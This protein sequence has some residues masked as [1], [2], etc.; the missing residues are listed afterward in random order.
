MTGVVYTQ[1]ELDVFLPGLFPLQIERFYRSASADRDVGMGHGW[2]HTLAWWIEITRRGVRVHTNDGRSVEMQKPA[3]QGDVVVGR[4]AWKLTGEARG[5]SLDMNDGFRRFFTESAGPGDAHWVLTEVRDKNGNAIRLDYDRGLLMGVRDTV[6]RAVRV[7]RARSG[8]IEAFEMRNAPE[9]GRW[10]PFVTYAYD[11]RRDLVSVTDA[12]GIAMRFAYDA[13]HRLVAEAHPSGLVFHFIYD[14]HGHCTET[15]GDYGG[16]PI[17]GL[18]ADVPAVLSN[19]RTRAK[20]IYHAKIDYHMAGQT[21]VDDSRCLRRV[22]GNSFG[23]IDKLATGSRVTTWNYNKV[24]QPVSREDPLNRVSRWQYGDDGMMRSYQD[25]SGATTT[26]ERDEHG[27]IVR[28]LEED[29]ATDIARNQAGNVTATRDS[30]G[31]VTTYERDGRGALAALIE[32]NGAR[33]EY[34]YDA[35]YNLV[36]LVDPLGRSYRWAYDAFGRPVAYRNPTNAETLYTYTDGGRELGVFLPNRGALRYSYDASGFLSQLELPDGRTALLRWGHYQKIIASVEPDGRTTTFSYD[37]EG[38]L[39]RVTNAAGEPYSFDRNAYGEATA[40]HTFDGRT[41][42]FDRDLGGRLVQFR[43]GAGELTEFTYDSADQILKME[44]GDGLVDSFEYDRVGRIVGATSDAAKLELKRDAAGNVVRELVT[45]NGV[46]RTIDRAYDENDEWIE[47]RTSLGHVERVDRDALGNRARTQLD[48]TWIQHAR[49]EIGRE[50]V[51]SLPKGAFL[52]REWDSLSQLTRQRVRVPGA[53]VGLGV[54]PEW[55]GPRPGAA[56]IDQGFSYSPFG[57]LSAVWDREAGLKRFERDATTRVIAALSDSREERYAYDARDSL[58]DAGSGAPQRRYGPGGRL[59]QRGNVQYR[60]DDA[61]RVVEKSTSKGDGIET[62]TYEWNGREQLAAINKPDGT[63]ISFQYDA[64]A[65]RVLKRV[66]KVAPVAPDEPLYE[67]QFLW[68]GDAPVHELCTRNG[69]PFVDER[70]FAFGD[71]LLEPL[72]QRDARRTTDDVAAPATPWN[73]YVLDPRGATEALVA[74]DG[75]VVWRREGTI[76]G[77]T[78]K[79]S[80]AGSTRSP[81]RLLGQYEDEET[82]LAYNRNRYYDSESGTF[83]SADPIDIEGGPNAFA[84]SSNPVDLQDPF[85]FDPHTATAVIIGEDGEEKS[86]LGKFNSCQEGKHWTALLKDPK[87]RWKGRAD[88]C[89]GKRKAGLF[90]L[91]SHTEK[92]IS[93]AARKAKI[94]PGDTLKIKGR[95][96]PCTTC[97]VF[98]RDLAHQTG[99]KVEYS[100][101]GGKWKYSGKAEE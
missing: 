99:C 28:V 86:D 21:E 4:E 11:E 91:L 59:L 55:M 57:L 90:S 92:K 13:D 47:L 71:E 83:L 74:D 24:G 52:E 97:Q 76:Y 16:L 81:F 58:F 9:Q 84:Y 63:R 3:A 31:R 44:Y 60:W 93:T 45:V 98:L 66:S 67:V 95:L 77:A 18:A 89:K 53:A 10:V 46:T 43:N 65:R 87:N 40:E 68:A 20:G 38:Y 19:G 42:R 94:G 32:P 88:K 1:P 101:K 17:P 96:P 35:Q 100:Y 14:S 23:K 39:R 50:R 79:E 5:F 6:G 85:G 70:T 25:A 34:R 36:E 49:D 62:W 26:F 72:A 2:S 56:S 8:H 33:Y 78:E 61:G 73:H 37:R 7:R 15:W 69:D 12:D 80:A 75:N 29:G 64:F 27:D 51:R 82:G 54:E 48:G 30:A 41:L 22:V